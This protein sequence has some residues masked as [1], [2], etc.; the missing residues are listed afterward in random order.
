M[1]RVL[2]ADD[3]VL[4]R[5]SIGYILDNE[6]DIEIVGMAG[7]GNEVVEKC[8]I[9]K[10]DIILMD[11]EMPS[12]NGVHAAKIIKE[13][14]EQVKV[15]ILTTFENADNIMEAFVANVDGYIVKNINH[16]DLILTIKCVN[17]GLT[18][19]HESV[20]KI[21]IERF[22]GLIDYKSQYQEILTKKDI[23]IVE[24]ISKGFSNKEIANS[25]NYSEG[26]IKNNVSKILEKLEMSDRI[27]IAIF[28]M[29]NGIV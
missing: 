20:K 26:T 22:K 17:S 6:K 29:E 2:L 9:L 15:I 10:P 25:L 19:I 5:E 4:L 24:L 14:N 28:A 1:I 7:D 21:M 27:Q 18:V 16:E 3:Q 8:E 13:K 12:L 11:I 23:K